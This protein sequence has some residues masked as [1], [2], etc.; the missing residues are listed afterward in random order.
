MSNII[1]I[2]AGPAGLTAAIYALRAGKSVTIF[3]RGVYGGQTVLAS[4]IENYPGVK[5]ITGSDFA[6]KLYEQVVD[7]GAKF[8]YGDVVPV[9]LKSKEK[10]LSI[11]GK[12]YRAKAVIIANGSVRSKLKCDG[13]ERLAGKGVSYCATCDGSFFKDKDVCVVG[14]TKSAVDDALYLS[15][16][17]K[18]VTVI[19]PGTQL[20]VSEEKIDSLNEKS[21]VEILYKSKANR[22]LGENVVEGIEVLSAE[23]GKLETLNVSAVFV[24]VG[25]SPTNEIFEDIL[26]INEK[27]YIV[28]GEDC[29]TPLDGVFVAGDTRTK[30]LRQIVT[31]VADGATAGTAAAK[32]IS[33]LKM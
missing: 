31:A 15:N 13:E 19:A 18:K 33:K 3:D 30:P 29:K 32:Y 1:I 12:E 8:A 22:I 28:A 23:N 4:E 14:G 25:T 17:C 20:K 7:L 26:P 2:G 5:S 6:V 24:A 11:G 16:I 27:G 9:D 10:V 21:N